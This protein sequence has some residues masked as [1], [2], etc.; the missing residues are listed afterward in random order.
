VIVLSRAAI[1]P[2][3]LVGPLSLFVVGLPLVLQWAL[4][5]APP[6]SRDVAVDVGVVV[7]VDLVGDVARSPYGV[8]PPEL[9]LTMIFSPPP[10]VCAGPGRE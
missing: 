6:H 9:V 2:R 7:V 10:L 3:S 5:T 1:T 4:V 8:V